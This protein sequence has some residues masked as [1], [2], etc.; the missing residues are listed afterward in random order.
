MANDDQL[1]SP[2]GDKTIEQCLKRRSEGGDAESLTFVL[3]T[4]SHTVHFC[5]NIQS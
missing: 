3:R 1:Q 4:A 5:G 2:G